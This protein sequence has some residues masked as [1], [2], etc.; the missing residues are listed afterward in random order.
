MPQQEL[1]ANSN[2]NPKEA[3]RLRDQ[4][5]KK[6]IDHADKVNEGWSD[7]AFLKFKEFLLDHDEFMSELFRHWLEDKLPAPPD[8]RAIG[9]VIV[10]AK[11]MGLIKHLRYQAATDP[12]SHR[13]P[14]SV[15]GKI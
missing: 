14:K 12:K 9:A 2:F 7:A 4:G 5:I 15:W 6:A 11:K 13:N 10:K 8:P 1:F 3:I